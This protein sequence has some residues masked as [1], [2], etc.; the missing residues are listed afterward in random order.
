MRLTPVVFALVLLACRLPDVCWRY[1]TAP[2]SLGYE[3]VV[4][5]QRRP[6]LWWQNE[7]RNTLRDK[8]GLGLIS[9]KPLPVHY[10]IGTPIVITTVP[11]PKLVR[12]EVVVES[13]LDG[14]RIPIHLFARTPLAAGP[15]DVVILIH[16]HGSS[17]EDALR[18]GSKL[19]AVGL[20]LAQAGFV[21]LVPEL[22]GFGRFRL[23]DLGHK[24][25]LRGKAEGQ[26]LREVMADSFS[27][28]EFAKMNFPN[29]NRLSIVG[30][31]L[32]GYIALHIA[33]LSSDVDGAVI[34][35]I[36]LPY[37][38]LNTDYHHECQRFRGI[39]GFAEVFDIAGLIAPR[40]LLIHFGE[41]D[42]FYTPVVQDILSKAKKIYT[43]LDHINALKVH[44]TPNIK[45][46]LDVD[47]TLA[48]LRH[49][50]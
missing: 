29:R 3:T 33:A 46:E 17:A 19:K 40:P 42:K 18:E 11:G 28:L 23:L 12:Q 43:G 50:L 8:L 31:S 26:F 48:F 44:V 32:G 15:T 35:G 34:S 41:Q 21:V 20:R 4:L 13:L 25:D 2:G 36:F 10:R 24:L 39:V 22:R 16:G 47:V 38:C 1:T 37:A 27:C 49:T 14:A 5:R 6:F 45:H 9:T 30:H 7:L